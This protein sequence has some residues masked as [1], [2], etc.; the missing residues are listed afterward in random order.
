MAEK[1][2]FQTIKEK[3]YRLIL[4]SKSPRRKEILEEMGLEFSIFTKSVEE[5]ESYTNPIELVK[6]NS[7]LKA[8]S[9]RGE[10]TFPAY[11]IGSDTVVV[12]QDKILGK[13]KDE[14]DA[15]RM[16][17][18]LKDKEHQVISGVAIF[19]TKADKTIVGYEITKVKMWNFPDEFIS[20][21]IATREPMDKAGAYGIQGMGRLLIEKIDGCY[22]N[23]VGLPVYRLQELFFTLGVSLL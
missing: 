14:E 11:I 20:K 18:L 22:Y 21:Y 16:L 12:Y 19:D 8:E 5:I 13:P 10:F 4:A 7:R 9:L 15:F 6:E 23:V 3:G 17:S 2:T 1:T